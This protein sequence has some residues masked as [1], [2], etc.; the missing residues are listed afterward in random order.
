MNPVQFR[1]TWCIDATTRERRAPCR[2]LTCTI[3]GRQ[4]Q[5]TTVSSVPARYACNVDAL[6]RAVELLRDRRKVVVFTGAGVS[7]DSGIPDFRSPG[8]VWTRYDPRHHE[9]TLSAGITHCRDLRKRQ[10]RHS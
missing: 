6:D 9:Q 8:G 7:T 4:Y 2:S 3:V 1:C 5:Q 10:L